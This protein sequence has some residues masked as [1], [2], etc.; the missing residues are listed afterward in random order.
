MTANS[1]SS[2]AIS[3][4]RAKTFLF[5]AGM[6]FAAVVI[7][8]V[9]RSVGA[10]L[11]A[12]PAESVRAP[13]AGQ[14]INTLFHGLLALA[15][16]IVTARLV[17]TAV[18]LIGQPTVIGEVCGGI[19]LGPSLLGYIA[20]GLYAQL[21]PPSLGSFLGVY[22]QLGVILYLFLVGLELDLGVLRDSGHAAL[23]ISHAS[24]ILPFLLGAGLALV[25][26]PVLSTADISFTV[27]ALFVGV[28]LSVTAFPVL[29]RILTDRRISKSSMGVIALTCAAI[30]DV[31]A[32]CLL[33]LVV[34][35]A[36]DRASD[37]IRTVALTLAFVFVVLGLVAPLARRMIPRIDR[38]ENLTRTGLS[39]V[40][41]A[42]L[43]SAMTTEYI[44]IHGFFGAF[45]FGAIIPHESRLARGLNERL[46]D[47]VAVLFLPA[48]FAYTGMRTQLALVSGLE[49]WLLC[50]LIILVA[51]LGKFGGTLIAARL[52]GLKW[53]DSAALGILMNTRGLVELI[54]L[55]LGLDLGILSPK[56]FTMLV[57]MALV[58]TFLTTP[59]LQL[60]LRKN[61]WVERAPSRVF[62][63][64][65]SHIRVGPMAG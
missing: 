50:G 35:I 34:S 16:I 60:L 21:L 38:S 5:Y 1:D 28:S 4:T 48:F 32:W 7:F 64:A 17:G 45:L 22:A 26:Y 6:V 11:A 31:T 18:G 62:D 37:A 59:I 3:A 12:P 13:A 8:F 24:I 33:A 46:D 9:I 65:S 52:S 40:F 56:L 29:A 2:S 55:N 20:P 58:T 30:D 47:I 15:V 44:G 49:N 42:M 53:R 63:G 57:I 61:P 41:I 43:A 25:L 14:A 36:H 54:V 27:F 10:D 19:M 51:C 23:A 39:V